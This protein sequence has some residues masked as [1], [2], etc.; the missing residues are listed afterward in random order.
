MARDLERQRCI[1]EPGYMAVSEQPALLCSVCGSGIV[2]ILWDSVRRIGGIAHCFFPKPKGREKRS[3]YYASVAVPQLIEHLVAAGGRAHRFEAHII[4]GSVPSRMK[5]TSAR[6]V[7]KT[8]RA[9]LKKRSVSSV[10]EDVY[11]SQG[12]KV[13][14]DTARGDVYV[15]K[16]ARIRKTDWVP[17]AAKKRGYQ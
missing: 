1:I 16:T 6:H 13:V 8:V 3:H 9:Y 11:G 15:M 5:D 12:R 2:V 17:A 10:M 4:G 7:V 14:F